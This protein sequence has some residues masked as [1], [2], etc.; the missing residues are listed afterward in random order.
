MIKISFDSIMHWDQEY[1]MSNSYLFKI[2]IDNK[3]LLI[4]R[5]FA[6]SGRCGG[7]AYITGR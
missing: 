4:N 5:G 6:V 3:Y 1:K 2:K 7:T